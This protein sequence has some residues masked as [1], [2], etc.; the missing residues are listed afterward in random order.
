MS[1]DILPFELLDEIFYYLDPNDQIKLSTLNIINEFFNDYFKLVA[2]KNKV[3]DFEHNKIIIDRNDNLYILSA[4]RID[5]ISFGCID[6]HFVYDVN[7]TPRHADACNKQQPITCKKCIIKVGQITLKC[8]RCGENE[9]FYKCCIGT[10]KKSKLSGTLKSF[11][12]HCELLFRRS[13][14]RRKANDI[15]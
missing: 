6:C 11:C 14:N 12:G 1:F 4:D 7:T 13:A 2:Y 9:T 8:Y 10:M 3:D 15:H 5:S